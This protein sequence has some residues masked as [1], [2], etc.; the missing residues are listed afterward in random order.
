[1]Q[2][3]PNPQDGDVYGEVTVAS[4]AVVGHQSKWY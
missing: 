3:I 2:P 1:M 4:V